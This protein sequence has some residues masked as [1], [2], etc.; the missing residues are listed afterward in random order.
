MRD[1]WSEFGHCPVLHAHA[2]RHNGAQV[3]AG[4]FC[5]WLFLNPFSPSTG[6]CLEHQHFDILVSTPQLSPLL[7]G[8]VTWW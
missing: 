4:K 2:N 3:N 6:L 1:S 5:G 8:A 7:G